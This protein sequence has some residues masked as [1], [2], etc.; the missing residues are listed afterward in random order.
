MSTKFRNSIFGFN[1]DD[2]MEYVTS[3]KEALNRNEQLITELQSNVDELTATN[4][5]YE[6]K[7]NEMTLKLSEATA[8]LED[9]TAR[10]AVLTKLSE[11]IGKLYLVAQANAKTIITSAEENARIT[12]SIVSSNIAVAENVGEDLAHIEAE[13][14][15][16]TA[17]F[18]KELEELKSKL[19]ETKSNVDRNRSA[20]SDSEAVLED[21]IENVDAEIKI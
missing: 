15:E 4:K 21:L 8:L 11:S 10:E 1:K 12:D 18:T 20:I 16:K 9:Y 3:S 2:V 7:L 17:R 19:E 5:I 14:T 6:D 13:L